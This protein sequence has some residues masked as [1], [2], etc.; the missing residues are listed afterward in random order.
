MGYQS[1]GTLYI[2]HNLWRNGGSCGFRSVGFV[3]RVGMGRVDV[4]GASFAGDNDTMA[5]GNAKPLI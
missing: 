4:G 5:T 3:Y 2:G 1:H